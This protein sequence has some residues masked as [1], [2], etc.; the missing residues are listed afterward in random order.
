MGI[1]CRCRQSAG[2]S[3]PRAGLPCGKD[4][5]PHDRFF[6][7]SE[8]AVFA[9][10]SVLDKNSLIPSGVLRCSLIPQMIMCLTVS[11]E[12]AQLS[13]FIWSPIRTHSYQCRRNASGLH[14][15]MAC[16]HKIFLL[17][18]W[19]RAG[20]Q[21]CGAPE[22]WRRHHSYCSTANNG[23]DAHKCLAE[24]EARRLCQ[25]CCL[26]MHVQVIPLFCFVKVN[27]AAASMAGIISTTSAR[28]GRH[29]CNDR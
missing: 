20:Q 7:L 22:Y 18:R 1:V 16:M 27:G 15:L 4:S 10:F 9:R 25:C 2:P 21:L 28:V 14:G 5:W 12:H 6:S 3:A 29:D 17:C 24:P 26:R 8:P 13:I 23:S 19:P 11:M